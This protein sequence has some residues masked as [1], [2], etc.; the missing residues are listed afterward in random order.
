MPLELGIQAIDINQHRVYPEG[1]CVTLSIDWLAH[2]LG[3]DENLPQTEADVRRLQLTGQ[4][5]YD[6]LDLKPE[7][8]ANFL[9]KEFGLTI[10]ETQTGRDFE[11]ILLADKVF[12]IGGALLISFWRQ[13]PNRNGVSTGHAVSAK[14]GTVMVE[15]YDPNL[16]YFSMPKAAF[17]N[18]FCEHLELNYPKFRGRWIIQRVFGPRLGI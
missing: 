17:K 9:F 11:P 5:H 1:A 8:A 7:Q 3:A 14:I 12:E 6:L 15:F 16:G 13:A 2:N 18:A 10:E 4:M